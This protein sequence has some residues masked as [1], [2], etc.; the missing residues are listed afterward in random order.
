MNVSPELLTFRSLIISQFSRG[1]FAPHTS[2]A[3]KFLMCLLK[4]NIF[5]HHFFY[6]RYPNCMVHEIKDQ[7]YHNQLSPYALMLHAKFGQKLDLLDE[8]F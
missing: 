5:M 8:C 4:K 2:N 3:S 7:E 6:S 1:I